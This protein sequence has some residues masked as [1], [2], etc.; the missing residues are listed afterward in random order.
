MSYTDILEMP[1][2]R[3]DEYLTWKIRFDQD[4]ERA[5]SDGLDRIRV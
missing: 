5:K 2:H 3:V 4:R 1:V